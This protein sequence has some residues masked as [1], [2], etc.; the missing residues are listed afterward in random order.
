LLLLERDRSAPIRFE[1]RVCNE[2]FDLLPHLRRYR[3]GAAGSNP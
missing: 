2:Y 3:R 1:V